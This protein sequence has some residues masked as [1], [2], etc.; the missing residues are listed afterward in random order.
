MLILRIVPEYYGCDCHECGCGTMDGIKHESV[1]VDQL[2]RELNDYQLQALGLVRVQA[3]SKKNVSD[4]AQQTLKLYGWVHAASE[5][6]RAKRK[7][8][9]QKFYI[10]N[11]KG[12]PY[13]WN[14][15]T[16]KQLDMDN[17]SEDTL[18]QLADGAEI[19]QKVS[20]KSVLKEA[21]YKKYL[22]AKKQ[23]AE[24][25]KKRAEASKAK[26]EAKK[27][28]EIEKAKKILEAA[29]HLNDLVEEK[30]KSKG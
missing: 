27:L 4:A 3:D 2:I 22:T 25:A 9:E 13:S 16:F 20:E 7:E 8:L 12:T 30:V 11:E 17:L 1:S 29:G 15:P 19:V 21:E 14:N 10:L 18:K 5:E 24:A 23:K 28:K 26:A 6:D